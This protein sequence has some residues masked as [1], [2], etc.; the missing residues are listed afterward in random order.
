MLQLP[1]C[2]PHCGKYFT[3]VGPLDSY[4]NNTCH[5]EKGKKL[6][7]EWLEESRKAT[8]EAEKLKD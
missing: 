5:C 2:C 4:H 7:E 3:Y 6:L 8:I 1:V